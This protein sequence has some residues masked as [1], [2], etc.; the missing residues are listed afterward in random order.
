MPSQG[1]ERGSVKVRGNITRSCTCLV[2]QSCPTL[3]DPMNCSLP[4]SS[5]HGISQARVLEWVAISYSRMVCVTCVSFTLSWLNL[6]RYWSCNV[7]LP[8]LL[9]SQFSSFPLLVGSWLKEGV[10]QNFCF[11]KFLVLLQ[12][13]VLVSVM[14]KNDVWYTHSSILSWRIPWTEEPGQP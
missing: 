3:C 8:F 14:F 5:V 10:L 12:H 4:G 11:F 13:H 7:L 6:P 1:R 2:A 9:W